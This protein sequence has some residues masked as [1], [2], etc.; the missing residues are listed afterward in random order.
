M[1]PVPEQRAQFALEPPH[2]QGLPKSVIDV[3]LAGEPA[4]KTPQERG[5]AAP[6][7]SIAVSLGNYR[8]ISRF[9][10]PRLATLVRPSQY[11]GRS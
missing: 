10:E 6:D 2:E 1:E 7:V 9:I 8:H 11:A 3:L 5:S 4:L